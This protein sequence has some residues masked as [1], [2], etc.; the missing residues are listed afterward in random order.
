MTII[1]ISRQMQN[2]DIV[3]RFQM[4]MSNIGRV[5]YPQYTISRQTKIFADRAA[6]FRQV[7][8]VALCLLFEHRVL[9]V[10]LF[11]VKCSVIW[12]DIEYSVCV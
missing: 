7:T 8:T 5:K 1:V 12:F 9:L 10:A 3:D 2:S 4:L 6:L 11:S